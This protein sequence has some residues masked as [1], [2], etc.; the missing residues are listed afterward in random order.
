MSDVLDREGY[1]EEAVVARGQAVEDVPIQQRFFV[2][3]GA[4]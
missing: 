3:E 2:S 4:L 1:Q